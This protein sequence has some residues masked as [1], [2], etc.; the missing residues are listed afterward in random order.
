MS[1]DNLSSILIVDDDKETLTSVKLLLNSSFDIIQLCDEPKQI[2]TFLDNTTYDVVLLDMNF[3]PNSCTGAE[4][5]YWL[6]EINHISPETRVIMMTAYGEVDLAIQAL[7]SGASDFIVKPWDKTKLLATVT[8]AYKFKTS[9]KKCTENVTKCKSVKSHLRQPSEQPI[10]GQSPIIQQVLNTIYLSAPTDAN[11][12]ILGENGT[13]KGLIAREI[14][15]QSSRNKSSFISIDL[16]TIAEGLFESELFGHKKGAFTGATQNRVGH[17]VEANK[18]TLFLDEVANLPTQLQTKL[19]S[20]LSQRE[21]KAIGANQSKSVDIRVIAAT[22]LPRSEL[23]DN[24]RFRQ[25][26]LYRLNTVEITLPALRERSEDIPLLVDYFLDMYSLKYNRSKPHISM[27][28]LKALQRY[29]WPGNVRELQN[30][31]E[32]AIILS[33][34]SELFIRDFQLAASQPKTEVSIKTQAQTQPLELGNLEKQRVKDALQKYTG[35]IS[36]AAKELGISRAALY[37]RIEKYE[38]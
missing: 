10:I 34:E 36:H 14:H 26:L 21:V 1:K 30:S 13:G 24:T 2:P 22:N 19:L 17:I 20:V 32:R 35:N 12:L 8:E 9:I 16:G 31:V 7:K 5:L 27:K 29:S 37:R 15:Q 6:S 18:G 38:L 23:L 25:D 3:S 28:T 4:G 11:I 33:N